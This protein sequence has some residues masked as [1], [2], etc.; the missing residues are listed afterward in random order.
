M[1]QPP[2]AYAPPT[3]P[4][5]EV[6]VEVI[7]AGIAPA[8]LEIIEGTRVIWRNREWAPPPGISIVSGFV[9]QAGYH[10]DGLFSSG[11]MVAPGEYWSCIFNA[12]GV[13]PYYI[14]NMNQ[15]GKIIVRKKA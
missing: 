4:I 13:Y 2:P 11:M 6:L 9:D 7:S 3:I 14:G 8:V 5:P 1:P 12:P 10:P 15:N